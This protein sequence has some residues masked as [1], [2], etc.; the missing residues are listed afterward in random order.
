MAGNCD[1]GTAAEGLAA[2]P[3]WPCK[4]AKPTGSLDCG[5][6]SPDCAESAPGSMAAPSSNPHIARLAVA[7]N[8]IQLL[9]SSVSIAGWCFVLDAPYSLKASGSR[10]HPAQVSVY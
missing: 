7:F 4:P 1:A 10:S 9:M 3:T 5:D 6:W 8:C 2:A